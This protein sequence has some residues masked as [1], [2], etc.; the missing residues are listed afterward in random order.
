MV[1]HTGGRL[2]GM[3]SQDEWDKTKRLIEEMGEMVT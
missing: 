3:V 1:T 2:C